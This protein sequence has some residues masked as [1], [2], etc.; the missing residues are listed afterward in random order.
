MA[1]NVGALARTGQYVAKLNAGGATPQPLGPLK[2]LAVQKGD[3]VVVTA[4]GLYPQAVRGGAF[5]FSLASFVAN[6]LQTAFAECERGAELPS[7]ST[8]T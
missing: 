3:T 6:L 5:A 1:Q 2:Q 4:Q 7:T 8:K